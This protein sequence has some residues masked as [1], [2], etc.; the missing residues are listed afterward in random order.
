MDDITLLRNSELFSTLLDDD[1]NYL[2]SRT[3]NKFYPAGEYVFR[4]GEGAIHFFLI[5]SGAVIISQAAEDGKKHDLAQYIAG[6]T[7]GEFDFVT[8]FLR[9]ADARVIKDCT[10]LVFPDSAYSIEILANEK[11]DTISRLY[12][13]FLAMLSKRLRSIHSLIAE[14]S[15]WVKQLQES[16]FVDQHTALYTRSFMDTEIPKLIQEQAALIIVKPD[17]FKEIN[18]SYGHQAGDA[19]LERMAATLL[20]IV[21]QREFS[22]A[23]RV[24]GNEMALILQQANREEIK[25]TARKIARTTA[26]IGPNRLTARKTDN[27]AENTFEEFRLTVSMSAGI[28]EKKGQN[29]NDFFRHAYGIMKKAWNDGGNKIY[30]LKTDKDRSG[31]N[32]G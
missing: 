17:R 27:T 30:F 5:K 31:S 12:L 20:Q 9:D 14:N 8:S 1:L 28:F 16:I 3:E 10:V 15:M 7:F 25:K 23:V 13:R 19:V 11:P 6:D 24:R 26:F 2:L 4:S 22:W 29:W 18:D 32:S 21:R